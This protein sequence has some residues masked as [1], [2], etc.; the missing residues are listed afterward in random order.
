MEKSDLN[1]SGNLNEEFVADKSIDLTAIA[2]AAAE[3]TKVLGEKPEKATVE[4]SGDI[5]KNAMDSEKD[6][7]RSIEYAIAAGIVAGKP[8]KKLDAISEV[9]EEEKRKI[10]E[11]INT[12]S[13]EVKHAETAF[14]FDIQVNLICEKSFTKVRIVNNYTNIILIEKNDD[15]IYIKEASFSDDNLLKTGE[16]IDSSH[17]I[18]IKDIKDIIGK[19][20]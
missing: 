15:I 17:F 9:T 10:K 16:N 2:Y 14:I 8:E 11:Y 3:A 19:K 5:I 13:I 1:Y 20:K 12:H 18:D 6:D 7:L 4:V